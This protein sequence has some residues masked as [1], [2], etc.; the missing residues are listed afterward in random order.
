MYIYKQVYL[1]ALFKT[2]SNFLKLFYVKLFYC[3]KTLS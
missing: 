3:M 1:T 2:H